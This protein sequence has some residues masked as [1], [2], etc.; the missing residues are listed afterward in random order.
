MYK[1]TPAI[2]EDWQAWL[3]LL[4]ASL[5]D[6]AVPASGHAGH[7]APNEQP[8]HPHVGTPTSAADI[9]IAASIHIVDECGPDLDAFWSNDR[10]L[11][12]QTCGYPLTHAL[13]GKVQLVATPEFDAP[14]CTGADYS[15]VFVVRADE[16]GTSLADYRGRHAALNALD[17]NSGMNVFRH[18]VAP[19]AEGGRFFSSVVTTGSHR[20]SMEAVARGDADLASIDCVT[21][22][23]AREALPELV[24][25]LKVIGRS[26]ATRALPL[27][28]SKRLD[29][30]ALERLQDALDASANEHPALMRR[31]KIRSFARVPLADYDGI[32]RIERDA[33]ELG[34]PVL[35]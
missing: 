8:M 29:A 16:G 7:L 1:L 33:V 6:I 22:A 31:L 15:S 32:E 4:E 30:H 12:S 9:R 2:A 34:Y 28:T 11:L 21:F 5:G 23:F 13:A 18:A 10:L 25:R 26:T 35:V 27:I 19:L 20:A 17:S 14:G 3:K 24:S